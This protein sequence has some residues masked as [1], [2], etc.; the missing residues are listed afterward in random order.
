M[1]SGWPIQGPAG[2]GIDVLEPLPLAKRIVCK[3]NVAFARQI[4]IKILVIAICLSVLRMA[5]R[6]QNGRI[7]RLHRGGN[8]EV[9]SN[10][11]LWETFEYD[12]LDPVLIPLH[13]AGNPRI[14]WRFFKG[15]SDKFPQS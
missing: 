6:S 5:N 9:S 11:N 13:D 4:L 7:G 12:V 3:N 15:P 14:E 2:L 10:V 8:I 1:F